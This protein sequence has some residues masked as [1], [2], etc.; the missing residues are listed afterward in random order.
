MAG[1]A[2]GVTSPVGSGLDVVHSLKAPSTFGFD[3]TAPRYPTDRGAGPATVR[4]FEV[5]R[6]FL[7]GLQGA[8]V[9]EPLAD[10]FPGRPLIADPSKAPDQYG[11]RPT[12]I[13]WL[14]ANS[15]PGSGRIFFETP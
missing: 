6:S 10:Q 1:F 5:P 13:D 14:R 3:G 7:E 12:Q 11:L 9:P 2:R 4:S 8:A 15:I